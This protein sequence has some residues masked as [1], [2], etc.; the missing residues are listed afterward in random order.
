MKEDQFDP[1]VGIA[2]SELA[3]LLLLGVVLLWC[4][5]VVKYNKMIAQKDNQIVE[6]AEKIEELE[7]E[8]QELREDTTKD[9]ATLIAE[10]NRYRDRVKELEK[11]ITKEKN[12][13]RAERDKAQNRVKELEKQLAGAVKGEYSIRKEL[14]GLKGNLDRVIFVLDCSGSMA[15][16]GRWEE[17]CNTT[18]TWLEHLSVKECAVI[19]FSNDVEVFEPKDKDQKWF[20]FSDM[21]GSARRKNLNY[22]NKCL[23][24][25]E[26]KGYTNT[27]AAL[28]KA[29]EYDGVGMIILFTDGAPT[30][31]PSLGGIFKPKMEF[32]ILEL[33]RER[34]RVGRNIPI[35]VVGIGDYFD[36]KLGRFLL[37]LAK[38]TEGSFIGK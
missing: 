4:Y 28:R 22:L 23:E 12:A 24:N 21:D 9:K 5:N 33:C 11:D 17:A 38:D 2:F 32:E 31:G 3:W 14:L 1:S 19:T 7:E 13:L 37:Q 6:Y 34:K 26:P 15:S 10:R 18:K 25:V 8:M 35:N 30:R 29:F 36:M 27:L 16:S 20:Q